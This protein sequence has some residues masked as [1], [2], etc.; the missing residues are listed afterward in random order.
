MNNLEQDVL[1]SVQIAIGAAIKSTLEG[2][3]SP[4][5]KLVT[6]VVNKHTGEFR[7]II[8]DSFSK[9]I[10]TDDFKESVNHAFNHKLARI[11]V[12]KMEGAIEKRVNELRSDPT[13]KAKMILAI[14]SLIDKPEPLK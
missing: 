10:L 14:Q 11:L 4:L 9:A 7:D 13:M 3:N 6:D 2:Y 5:N 12:D 8:E 1:R